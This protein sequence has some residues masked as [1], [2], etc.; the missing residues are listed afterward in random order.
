LTLDK[1]SYLDILK[2][3]DAENSEALKLNSKV[4]KML[5]DLSFEKKSTQDDLLK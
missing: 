2:T 4:A 3:K 5:H 1:D